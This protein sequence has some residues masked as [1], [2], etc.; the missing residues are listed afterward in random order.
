MFRQLCSRYTPCFKF[1]S[2]LGKHTIILLATHL[3]TLTVI[4]LVFY[5]ILGITVFE[6]NEWQKVGLTV[7]QIILIIPVIWLVNKYAPI[8]D[9]KISKN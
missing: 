6:F 8:L 5:L 3:R 1:F 4:K 2:Y 9:G 7:L